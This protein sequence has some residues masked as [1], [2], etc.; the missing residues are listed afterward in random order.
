[1]KPNGCLKLVRFEGSD[2]VSMVSMTCFWRENVQ[3]EFFTLFI[4]EIHF[5]NLN[6]KEKGKSSRG[7]V[8]VFFSLTHTE[9]KTF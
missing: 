1:M 8:F 7:G 9:V 3:R 2:L 4:V 6:L 5:F